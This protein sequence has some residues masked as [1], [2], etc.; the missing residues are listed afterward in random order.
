MFGVINNALSDS[1]RFRH[2]F[3]ICSVI[4]HCCMRPGGK[5]LADPGALDEL[6]SLEIGRQPSV[7]PFLSLS[8]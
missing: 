1:I 6:L 4:S 7:V 2:A 3:I 5:R 8:V